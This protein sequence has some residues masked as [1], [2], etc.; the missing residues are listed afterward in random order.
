M[1]SS[2]SATYLYSAQL[3][4][5]HT[6]KFKAYLLPYLFLH[7]DRRA[8]L[9]HLADP[10]A[11][12]PPVFPQ[13]IVP[14]VRCSNQR[15]PVIGTPFKKK[16]RGRQCSSDWCKI[17]SSLQFATC[18]RKSHILKL[19]VLIYFG[20]FDMKWSRNTKCCWRL[21]WCKNKNKKLLRQPQLASQPLR[22]LPRSP[23]GLIYGW[24]LMLSW[25]V[26]I[27][28]RKASNQEHLKVKIKSQ[29]LTQALNETLFISSLQLDRRRC[30]NVCFRKPGR[31]A[32]SGQSALANRISLLSLPSGK[33]LGLLSL[34]RL[35]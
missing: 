4:M 10:L 31:W 12:I 35:Q 26:E 1:Y 3:Q 14:G 15:W 2:F 22:H 9:S 6:G 23:L 7:L 20:T 27:I 5:S 28:N 17:S 30:F 21:W 13:H 18:M 16:H 24:V 32:H 34:S 19:K 11:G 29:H 25:F 8:E 33:R